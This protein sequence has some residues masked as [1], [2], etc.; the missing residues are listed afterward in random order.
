MEQ[1]KKNEEEKIELNDEFKKALKAIEEGKNIFILGKAGT[2][3]STF[4]KLLKNKEGTVFLAATGI[5]ALNIE[6][7]T[8]HSFF[9]FPPQ[10]HPQLA[11]EKAKEIL[12]EKKYNRK[13]EEI[14]EKINLL[15][16]IVIDEI[17]MVRAD[18]LDS[19][20]IFLKEIRGSK[21][22]FGGV[23]VVTIGDIFQLPPVVTREEE[24]ILQFY[25]YKSPHFFSAKSFRDFEVIEFV[26]VYRQKDPQFLEILDRIRLGRQTNKDLKFLN[27]RVINYN[28]D[29][30]SEDYIITLAGTNKI[31][32]KINSQKLANLKGK[33]KIFKGKIIGTFTDFP[34]PKEL[35]LKKGTQIVFLTNRPGYYVNGELG[36]VVGY[37]TYYDEE[38]DEE[39]EG[40][41]VKK[42]D[43]TEVL[44]KNFVWEKYEYIVVKKKIKMQ[45]IGTFTQLPIKP[46]WALTIHK[47]QGLTLQKVNILLD[48]A[49][50]EGQTYVALSRVKSLTGLFLSKKIHHAHIIVDKECLKFYEK[51]KKT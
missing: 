35:K 1:K 24:I 25:K 32:E 11:K 46:A 20:D 3:K 12:K 37:E 41:L 33:E 43:G 5:A 42:E 51:I 38:E 19:I 14:Y 27:K 40:V 17:S 18:L 2:G 31:V 36:I 48:F 4:L 15:Q 28:D 26:K 29:S 16:T 6:G 22:P 39:K 10:I 45:K 49:F 13:K 21:E 9:K 50:A 47:S 23:Q 30:L 8:I 7:Q 34:A 44:V